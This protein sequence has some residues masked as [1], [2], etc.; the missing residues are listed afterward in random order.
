MAT[1]F[2]LAILLAAIGLVTGTLSV[3]AAPAS[4]SEATVFRF[5]DSAAVGSSKLVRTDSGVSMTL[6]TSELEPGNAV[7]VW[8]VIFNNP[9]ECDAPCDEPDL[10]KLGVDGS[11][12]YAA[13]NIVGANGKINF[14]GHLA[15]GD[16][17]GM[18]MGPGL[19]DTSKAEIHLAVHPHGPK[20]PGLVDS[21]VSTFLGGC[22]IDEWVGLLGLLGIS[23]EALPLRGEP[24]PNVCATVQGAAHPAP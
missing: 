12:G 11:F 20:I 2:S 6:K 13:G 16:T 17:S 3:L 23:E 9:G 15:E 1:K 14:G 7:T 4:Q 8:W 5:S 22:R 24:G 10:F 21:Q 19:L 18:V